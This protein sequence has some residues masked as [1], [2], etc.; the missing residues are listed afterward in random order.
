MVSINAKST[1]VC[2]IMMSIRSTTE[3][4]RINGL[5]AWSIKI[6]KALEKHSAKISSG[7]GVKD[8]NFRRIMVQKREYKSIFT[9]RH[10]SLKLPLNKMDFFKNQNST[11]RMPQG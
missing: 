4:Q 3:N 8:N 6:I 1:Q 5:D 11:K 2:L 9:S 7:I 10:F